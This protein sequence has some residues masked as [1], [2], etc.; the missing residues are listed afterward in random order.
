[1]DRLRELQSGKIYMK[2]F[3][4][5]RMIEQSGVG[6]KEE[7]MVFKDKK[8]FLLYGEELCA[9]VKNVVAYID[10]YPI[11]CCILPKLKNI[12]SRTF[13][14]DVPKE[15]IENF[16]NDDGQYGILLIEKDKFLNAVD[17]S[18]KKQKLDCYVG[19]VF[20]TNNLQ[21]PLSGKV[22]EVAFRK[23][24]SFSYQS[25][26]RIVINKQ[27]EDHYILDIGDM[28][29]YSRMFPITKCSPISITYCMSKVK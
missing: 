25:E 2:T 23:R 9:N 13:R 18:I 19:R 3:K 22:H 17:L 8:G 28:T 26:Y 15:M 12:N 10:N 20:Y 4:F 21:M 5:F 24:K 16:V 6:D 29:N 1:M 14:Y 27:I 7:G 11:F